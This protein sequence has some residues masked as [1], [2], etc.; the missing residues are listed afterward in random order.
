MT[1]N[2]S[3]WIRRFL[4][5][6]LAFAA[7]AGVSPPAQGADELT[8]TTVEKDGAKVW[9]GSGSIDL[10]GPVTLKVKNPL[11]AEHGFAIDTMKVQEVIK[12]GEEKTITVPLA[13]IDQSA[14]EHRVY[15]QLHPK[16]VP[17]TIKVVK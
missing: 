8:F 5:L 2:V 14:A 6:V 17:A 12:P 13:N 1:H 15:C 11:A 16:H 3:S 10:K 4:V 9:E 7:V